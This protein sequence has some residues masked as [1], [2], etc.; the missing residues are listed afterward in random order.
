MRNPATP[1]PAPAQAPA[2]DPFVRRAAAAV[3]VA[4]TALVLLLVAWQGIQI[5][6]VG[7]GGVLFAVFL[8]ALG[9][10]LRRYL[11]LSVPW[12]LTA[13]LTVLIGLLALG[14]WLLG[15]Q[16]AE[17]AADVQQQLPAI[18]AQVEEYLRQRPWGAWLL[19]RVQNG[20]GGEG[21]DLPAQVGA[22]LG[23]LSLWLGYLLTF[24]FVGLFAAASPRMYIDGIVRLVPVRSRPRAREVMDALGYTLRWWLIGRAIAMVMVGVSTAIL[25][26]LLGAPFAPLLGLVA[27]LFTFVPYLGPFAAGIPIALVTLLDSPQLALYAVG[28]YTLVQ[29]VEGYVLDPLIQQKMVYLPPVL[30][31]IAQM[32]LGVLLGVLGI[33]LATPLA[34]V[35][36]VLTRKLYVESVLGDRSEE[37]DAGT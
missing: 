7:F 28:A 27:G 3:A 11:G 9:A 24:L 16:L 4:A 20:G 35:A 25:L 22:V 14:V 2:N 15:G 13:V 12:A 23:G 29:L 5:L 26:L 31:L 34:A 30:T 19:D 10:P 8:H 6:L 37:R 33:A 32:M 1:E 21:S 18:A 17:Q 36:M